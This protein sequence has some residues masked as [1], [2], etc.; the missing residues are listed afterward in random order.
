MNTNLNESTIRSRVR[1]AGYRLRKSRKAI[2]PDN[3][4]GYMIVYL[5]GMKGVVVAGSSYELSL[6]DVNNWLNEMKE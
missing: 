4:G 1:A 2:D 3:L 6:E 5:N